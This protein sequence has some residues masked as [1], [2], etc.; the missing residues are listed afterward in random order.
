MINSILIKRP[1]SDGSSDYTVRIPNMKEWNQNEVL[2]TEKYADNV[3]NTKTVLYLHVWEANT[4]DYSIYWI[5]NELETPS[6]IVG[7]RASLAGCVSMWA[8]QNTDNV[9]NRYNISSMIWRTL[10][11]YIVIE[12]E[13][14]Q[15]QASEYHS[16]SPGT[17]L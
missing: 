8:R 13:E 9:Y 2:A 7:L 3:A 12:G 14:N 6:N 16:P 17:R 4:A 15:I 10:R 11:L 1:I 5:D